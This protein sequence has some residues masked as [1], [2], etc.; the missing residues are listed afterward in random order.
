MQGFKREFEKNYLVFVKGGAE[1]SCKVI[2][3]CD[4]EYLS[5]T[6]GQEGGM[7]CDER[8]NNQPVS[9][10]WGTYRIPMGVGHDRPIIC[11]MQKMIDLYK[12]NALTG[13]IKWQYVG[14]QEKGA[15]LYVVV[16]GCK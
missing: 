12:A 3:S 5:S 13:D 15:Y 9:F 2:G 14:E 16:F 10:D 4:F 11:A 1:D 8:F 7:Q 6:I